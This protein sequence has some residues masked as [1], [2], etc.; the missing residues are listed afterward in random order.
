[1]E[2]SIR[3]TPES[4]VETEIVPWPSWHCWTSH[5]KGRQGQDPGEP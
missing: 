4:G 3:G 5:W 2:R 1:M